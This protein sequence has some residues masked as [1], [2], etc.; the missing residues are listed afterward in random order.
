MSAAQ[1]IQAKIDDV[2]NA[3]V[4]AIDRVAADVAA[5]QAIIVAGNAGNITPAEVTAIVD[6]LSSV[7][8]ALDGL[9]PI[10]GN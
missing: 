6:G 5:L 10:P 3:T 1:D 7:K 4:A 2:K 8:T 9:D